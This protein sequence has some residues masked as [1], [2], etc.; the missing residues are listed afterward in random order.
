MRK[1][2]PWLTA[3]VLAL[4]ANAWGACAVV[5]QCET[6]GTA[7][8]TSMSCGLG[9][10]VTAGNAI[11]IGVQFSG[12]SQVSV[13]VGNGTDS[14]TLIGSVV[15]DGGTRSAQ[16]QKINATG[17]GS[18]TFT[19]SNSTSLTN[20][21]L[22]VV[23]LS[24]IDTAAALVGSANPAASAPGS[25]T[26][27]I[28][29]GNVSNASGSNACFIGLGVDGTIDT[30][31]IA[32]GTGATSVATGWNLG[33][34]NPGARL[35]YKPSLTTGSSYALTWTGGY[36]GHTYKAFGAMFQE[37]GG[38]GGGTVISPL[39]GGGGAAA[40]PVQAFLPRIGRPAVLNLRTAQ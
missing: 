3:A 40:K 31:T 12:G 39:G 1:L 15:N 37:A 27:A 30:I 36:G 8:A 26:D 11:Y 7:G 14:L 21:A 4:C 9:A 33:T 2:L 5:Q 38:G 24:G 17:G 23:E 22:W 28:T 20:R 35:E 16:Y 19:W 32:T 10:A 34:A 18:T 25:G 6:S 29:T 13:T